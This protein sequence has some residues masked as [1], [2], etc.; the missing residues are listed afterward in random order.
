MRVIEIGK[1]VLWVI[2]VSF[3]A[4]Y[5][6]AGG[7]VVFI[8][9]LLPTMGHV[10]QSPI[11]QLSMADIFLLFGCVLGTLIG[12]GLLFA[13]LGYTFSLWSTSQQKGR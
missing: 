3:A 13:L 10:F 6:C 7:V 2:F 8:S 1:K 4:L 5:L 12:G 11:S 9:Y